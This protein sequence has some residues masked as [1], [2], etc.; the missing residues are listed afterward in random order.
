M[1]VMAAGE[2]LHGRHEGP[3]AGAELDE[4]L[5]M[6]TPPPWHRRAACRDHPELDWFP[7]RG[8]AT[9]P[10][11][12]VCAGCPVRPQCREAAFRGRGEHFGMWAGLS[13]RGAPA[14]APGGQRRGP[15]PGLVTRP[16]HMSG[17]ERLSRDL[18]R[19]VAAV[20]SVDLAQRRLVGVQFCDG[21]VHLLGTNRGLN[22]PDT[23]NRSLLAAGRPPGWPPLGH[24]PRTKFRRVLRD[25]VALERAARRPASTRVDAAPSKDPAM[26]SDLPDE[27]LFDGEADSLVALVEA[28]D[29]AAAGLLPIATLESL[30]APPTT[31][32]D[33]RAEGMVEEPEEFAA[34]N[35][36]RQAA[37][38]E[39][40]KPDR[41]LPRNRRV[42]HYCV[43]PPPPGHEER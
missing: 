30:E 13:E 43:I 25:A 37:T 24:R 2:N 8:M 32:D 17:L 23:F 42:D 12:L 29:R 6:L 3:D 5:D 38:L 20:V 26:P 35:R 1:S 19:C 22:D 39:W 11:K 7:T 28:E 36:P 21:A 18:D 27:P 31:F 41:H 16:A 34:N 4:L 33:L 14:P 10:Q 15:P 9:R 40:M